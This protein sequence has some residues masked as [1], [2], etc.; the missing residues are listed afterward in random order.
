MHVTTRFA[1]ALGSALLA[2]RSSLAQYTIDT[3]Y[4]VTNFYDTW[5][6]FNEAD[7]TRGYVEYLDKA[8]ANSTG[9]FG[10]TNGHVFMGVDDKVLNPPKGR[11]SVRVSS[12]KAFTHGLFI[13][14][15]LHMPGSICGTWP[16]FWMFGDTW[17][18]NG[19][20][21]IIEGVNN[22]A[23]GAITL[24]TS[25]GCVMSNAGALTTSLL[26]S[27]DCAAGNSNIGCGQST[28]DVRNYGDI[29]NLNGGGVYATEW[30]SDHIA[31]WFFAR[32]EI[33]HDITTGVPNPASWGLPSAKFS[34]QGCDI[35]SHFRQHK[36]T[37]DTTFCG[38]WAGNP[39]VWSNM[40]CN[41]LAP[42]CEQYVGA[43]PSAF[44]EAYWEVDSVK[45][46]Q[47]GPIKR[48][49]PKPFTA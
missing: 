36:L 19:E 39:S 49:I 7:P 46:Y 9:L 11:Q 45:I 43:N 28:I 25:P 16:A 48:S 47:Q 2:A 15:I 5:D 10:R 18:A 20:I 21:D 1:F 35:D 40:K 33:P 4:D 29:F 13:A 12:Q 30:T 32:G 38:D 24:H 22:Q 27:G 41:A 42:T 6:F 17:P 37:F 34:G 44:T 31:V 3:T 14:D 8:T 26:Q 23:S